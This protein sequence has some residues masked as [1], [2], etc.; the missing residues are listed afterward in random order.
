[1]ANAFTD[2][3]VTK[4]S[5][6]RAEFPSGMRRDSQKDKPRFDLCTAEGLPFEAQML[7]RWASLM[8]RG[9]QKYGEANWQLGDGPDELRR[10]RSSAFRHFM[11]WFCG[12]DDGEDHAAATFFNIMAAEYFRARTEEREGLDAHYRNYFL[13]LET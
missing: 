13:R 11:Q 12:A 3:F 2:R 7:T 1:M 10:A 8:E 4:D 9:A 6:E 5:G